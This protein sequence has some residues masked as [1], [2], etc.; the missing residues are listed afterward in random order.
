MSLD[1][2]AW[3]LI[4]IC[5][6]RFLA[7]FLP[8]RHRL[9][10]T[11]S[12]AAMVVGAILAFQFCFNFP[13]WFIWGEQDKVIDNTTITI[14]CGFTSS[15]AETYWTSIHHYLAISVYCIIPF[16]TMLTLNTLIICKLRQVNKLAARNSSKSRAKSR[17]TKTSSMTTMLLCVTFYF[18][19]I[20][21][22]S[23]IFTL[24][25]EDMFN[26]S[27]ITKEKYAK[28]EL[29]DAVLTIMLYINHSINFFLYCLTGRR[30]RMELR[31]LLVSWLVK[32][33][34]IS[35]TSAKNKQEFSRTSITRSP[36]QSA[37]HG[38]TNH[39]LNG[40]KFHSITPNPLE[41]KGDPQQ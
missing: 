32:F 31:A 27:V 34:I 30:F 23:F 38:E 37:H 16:V 10:K 41:D 2:S 12:R 39:K 11:P 6:E 9:L 4:A 25:Q 29:V 26:N 40:Q 28:M 1:T 19:M 36:G 21:A 14:P 7:V 15:D 35:R 3:I 22:P 24:V 8:H 18:I 5:V 13:V 33:R 20:T 17:N